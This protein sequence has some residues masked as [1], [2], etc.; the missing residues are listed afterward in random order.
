M[1]QKKCDISCDIFLP[2]EQQKKVKIGKPDKTHKNYIKNHDRYIIID[3]KLEI[4]LS[5][6]VDYLFDTGK[7]FTYVI[8]ET[9]LRD[10]NE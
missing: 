6:G 8:R 2:A 9:E 4:I 10:Q 1:L 5:S 3:D 7:D